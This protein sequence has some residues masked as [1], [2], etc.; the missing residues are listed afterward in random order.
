MKKYIIGLVVLA[1]FLLV[2]FFAAI[3]WNA[4]TNNVEG[5]NPLPQNIDIAYKEIQPRGVPSVARYVVVDTAG[6]NYFVT[7]EIFQLILTPQKVGE[8]LYRMPDGTL[9][10]SLIEKQ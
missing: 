4:S 3:V 7:E 8:G 9:L 5:N 6:Y 2:A 10:V 1:G